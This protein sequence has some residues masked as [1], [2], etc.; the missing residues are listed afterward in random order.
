VK[1]V[2]AEV[3]ELQQKFF[4][5]QMAKAKG[6][7]D[8]AKQMKPVNFAWKPFRNAINA[9]RVIASLYTKMDGMGLPG[10]KGLKAKAEKASSAGNALQ[11]KAKK[12]FDADLKNN[13]KEIQKKFK[14][15]STREKHTADAEA[16][17]KRRWDVMWQGF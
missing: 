2:E 15:D 12:A 3:N 6:F 7:A 9:Y 13:I 14:G 4:D 8:A 11:K 5:S 17:A 10:S 16:E 1:E